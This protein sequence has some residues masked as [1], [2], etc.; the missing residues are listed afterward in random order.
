MPRNNGYTRK[1]NTPWP[2]VSQDRLDEVCAIIISKLNTDTGTSRQVA[3]AGTDIT[4]Y[5]WSRAIARL[6]KTGT[7]CQIGFRRGARHCLVV[8]SDNIEA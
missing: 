8:S 7:V 4:D 1:T 2:R 3:T 6:H 5:E